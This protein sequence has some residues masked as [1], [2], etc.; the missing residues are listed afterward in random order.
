MCLIHRGASYQFSP[1]TISGLPSPLRS[2]TAQLSLA[3]RSTVCFSNGISSGR[4]AVHASAPARHSPT[5]IRYRIMRTIVPHHFGAPGSGT[6]PRPVRGSPCQSPPPRKNIRLPGNHLHESVARIATPSAV[7]SNQ[8]GWSSQDRPRCAKFRPERHRQFVW[9][10]R[11][12]G[13]L[14]RGGKQD[15]APSAKGEGRDRKEFLEWSSGCVGLCQSS[16]G[17]ALVVPSPKVD[18]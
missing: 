4:P 13:T 9:C 15:L 10:I 7:S 8:K 12:L 5:A 18:P 1:E 11:V 17:I 16:Y 3:P 6:R 2:A 14:E